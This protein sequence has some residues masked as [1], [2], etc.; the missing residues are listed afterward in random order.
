M[1]EAGDDLSAI[2]S[3]IISTLRRIHANTMLPEVAIRYGGILKSR[4]GS[5]P[6]PL[7]RELIRDDATVEVA[8]PGGDTVLIHPQRLT[9]GQIRQVFGDGYIR[10]RA[11]QLAHGLAA[12]PGKRGRPP[13][14]TRVSVDKA[15]GVVHYHGHTITKA[16][17][18]RWINEL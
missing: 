5:L 4:I 8:M 13:G 16:T 12:K 7:Q 10:E 14:D 15:N 1:E 11:E 2:P 3:G 9:P 6:L 17:L 18:L